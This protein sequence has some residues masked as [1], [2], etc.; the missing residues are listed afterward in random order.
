MVLRGIRI[1]EARVRFPVSPQIFAGRIVD[2]PAFGRGASPPPK[3]G[4]D[5]RQVHKY[6][7]ILPKKSIY[8]NILPE[9]LTATVEGVRYER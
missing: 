3:A 2:L 1:A 7:G 4:R 9:A 8:E 5:S 6:H